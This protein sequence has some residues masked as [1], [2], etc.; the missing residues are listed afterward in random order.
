MIAEFLVGRAGS[1][2][3]RHCL[4]SVFQLLAESPS[5]G[6]PLVLLVPEQASLQTER[7]LVCDGPIHATARAQVLSFRRLAVRILD[8]RGGLTGTPLS[9][10]G[11]AMLLRAVVG[12][13]G[14]RLRYYRRV[15]R[16][17]GFFDRLGATIG[18]L[19]EGNVS[20][21]DLRRIAQ[22]D[23][24]SVSQRSLKLHDLAE[25]HES[26]LNALGENRVD[27]SR[28]LDLSRKQL[29]Q[30][31][32][33]YGAKF[34]VDGFAG[35][36]ELERQ[37]LCDLVVRAQRTTI[38][39]L[40]DPAYHARTTSLADIEP[41]DLF[42]PTQRTYLHLST[43][44][45]QR[46]V[47]VHSTVVAE[48]DQPPR[49]T[50][51][52][53][54]GRLECALS[55]DH[56]QH[57][58]A[59]PIDAV[60]LIESPS[61]RSEVAYAVG[62][63]RE[64]VTRNET[65]LRYRDIA[66]VTRDLA[67]YHDLIAEALQQHHI[68]YFIDHRRPAGHHPL[69][70]FVRACVGL[71]ADDFGVGDVR[72]LL[73]TGLTA[74]SESQADELENH[75]LALGLSGLTRWTTDPW[76]VDRP[77]RRHSRQP[78]ANQH[79]QLRLNRARRTVLGQ[80]RPFVESAASTQSAIDWSKALLRLLE[81]SGAIKRVER[82]ARR[83]E[84]EGRINLADSHRQVT[85]LVTALFDD[86]ASGLGDTLLTVRELRGVLDA[87]FSQLT[88]GLA[89]PTV[90]QVLI[91][92]IDRSRNP[93]LRQVIVLGLNEGVFPKRGASDSLLG[94]DDRA[95]LADYP[96]I[97][98]SDTQRALDEKLLLYIAA[99][100]AAQRVTFSYAAASDA[101]SQ[102]LE[103]SRFVE[104][105]RHAL[106][107]LKTVAIAETT[108][109]ESIAAFNGADQIIDAIT[110]DMRDR[111]TIEQDN[112]AA[113][114]RIND[115]Y[116][117]AR[118]FAPMRQPL[119]R[120]LSALT[121]SNDA[122]LSPQS[123]ASLFP[124]AYRTSVS[125]LE[126]FAAC[127]FKRFARY[128]LRLRERDL[129]PLE[130]R[131]MGTVHHA[132]LEDL[133]A[134]MIRNRDDVAAL[135]ETQLIS[136]L[137]Q[138]SATIGSSFEGPDHP[139]SARDAHW[140]RQTAKRLAPAM[141]QQLRAFQCGDFRPIA[142]EAAFGIDDA[143]NSLPALSINT[144]KGRCV[145]FRGFIDRVD[146]A[147]CDDDTVGVVVDYKSNDKQIK[148]YEIRHGLAL[149]LVAYMLALRDIGRDLIGE[150]IQPAGAIYVTLR[151]RYQK[152]DH[153]EQ[154]K[155]ESGQTK[156]R[157]ILDASKLDLFE[158][159]APDGWSRVL[160]VYRK[161]DGTL[162]LP[163]K[164]DAIS[165]DEFQTV[166]SF[167]EK[168]LGHLADDILDGRIAVTPYRLRNESPCTY[169]EYRPVC[170]FEIADGAAR[171]LTTLKRN[172]AIEQMKSRGK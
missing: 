79:R 43:H 106:P 66:I 55:A 39:L 158:N 62:Q 16:L 87:G 150:S 127:P 172:D 103:P 8:Q 89:P 134:Q 81:T 22:T 146:A 84:G 155:P 2:K 110:D 58:D 23:V 90:D 4:Q 40:V 97:G 54:I 19:I 57:D 13:L 143:P 38:T 165:S 160:Q 94:N 61:R 147:Q 154:A 138:S 56:V 145:Q 122:T 120:A 144:P 113:R 46:G 171:Y 65:P 35:F 26:Y 33:L 68:P 91:G 44:L 130:A 124:G 15:D 41:G 70:E 167:V 161:K 72:L 60:R 74:L 153:P 93:N 157:G 125:E 18:E 92:S 132:V 105:L 101:R 137:E 119:Q 76:T 9:A 1:G 117:T 114:Q 129:S 168:T 31:D 42:A 142:V 71:A 34:W 85:A 36:T 166:L 118:T 78:Q 5:S 28:I 27:P 69:V 32:F 73:K 64:A 148:L 6:P 51:A 37:L 139:A 115:L 20:P 112:I 3:S 164:T 80:V 152:V 95:L 10:P 162:G 53:A 17:T 128:G 24:Q 86:L 49:F 121:E 75:I 109:P 126:T 159:D 7:A 11:R 63:I 133:V 116:T 163:D 67:L 156:A 98:V 21:D 111:P 96:E 136:R 108:R 45:A 14:R 82:W 12:Q 151:D 100:R 149:Q 29:A 135:D 59:Q 88:L 83:A 123:A 30:S 104:T 170:R 50:S 102:L 131:D 169:C 48:N 141:R 107:G 25:I 47:T 77:T 99:T 52:P 140:I